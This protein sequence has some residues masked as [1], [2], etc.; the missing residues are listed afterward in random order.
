[1]IIYHFLLSKILP[2]VFWQI[3]LVLQT[4]RRPAETNLICVDPYVWY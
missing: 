3:V 4:L 1:M 2:L